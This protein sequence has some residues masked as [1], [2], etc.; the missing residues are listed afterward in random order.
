MNLLEFGSV[1]NPSEAG[2]ARSASPRKAY[3]DRA[4]SAM[5]RR[6]GK[7]AATVAPLRG[8]QGS[9]LLAARRKTETEDRLGRQLRDYYQTMLR[10]P[11]PER[12]VALVQ[13]LD[14]RDR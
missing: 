9:A 2:G 14:E 6:T 4:G 7:G 11:V 10:E 1:L 5:L 12:L 8:D 3:D 13:S